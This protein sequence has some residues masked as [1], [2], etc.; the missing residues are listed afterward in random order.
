MNPHTTMSTNRICSR[1]ARCSFDVGVKL[2]NKYFILRHGQTIYQTKKKNFIYPSPFKKNYRVKLTKEGEKQIKIAA[3]RLK[4]EKIDIIFAS[5]F[6]R[7]QQTG[8]I[9]GKRLGKKVFLD[10][11]LRDV[12]LGIYRGREKKKFYQVFSDVRER[13]Y[14]KIPGGES[15]CDTQKRMIK[16][17][18]KIDKKFKNKKILIISHGDPLWLLEG[19]IKKWPAEKLLKIKNGKKGIIKTGELRKL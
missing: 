1:G 3:Q 15:W 12:N 9:V 10:K 4:K 13:F 2:R 6:F 5:D 16:F 8:R 17:L 14:K 11:R 19:A 18:E 7:T